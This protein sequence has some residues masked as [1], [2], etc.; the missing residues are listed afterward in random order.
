MRITPTSVYRLL[1]ETWLTVTR[2]PGLSNA[3]ATVSVVI[4]CWLRLCQLL[5][6]SLFVATFSQIIA[7]PA[8]EC[9]RISFPS[10]MRRTFIKQ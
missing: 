3:A 5:S 7:M 4:D 2:P 10:L 1:P 8:L 9:R 6:R